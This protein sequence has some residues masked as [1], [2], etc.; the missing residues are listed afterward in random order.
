MKISGIY[1]KGFT[2][3][4]LSF[5]L[6]CFF[7]PQSVLGSSGESGGGGVTVTP[8][9]S[10]IIQI[11]NFLFLI[12][13]L[14]ILLY[15]PIRKI[16]AQRKEKIDG[17]ELS[18]ITS[19]KDA[20]EKDEAFAAGIKEARAKGLREKEVLMQQALDEEKTIIADINRKAQAELAEIRGK[21]K[22]EAEVARESL[23][24]EVD[25]FANQI[26]QKIIGRAV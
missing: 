15:K 9:G 10:V 25:N 4:L 23:Q 13:V 5:A 2:I 7:L 11:I 12:W 19:D 6:V 24:K 16:L 17:L 26:C 20:L 8:D 3:F 14:N 18:I 1:R 22:K 21:I